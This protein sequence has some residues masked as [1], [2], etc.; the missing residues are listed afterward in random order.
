M[1][2]QKKK[3]RRLQNC[4]KCLQIKT[5][6]Y[7]SSGII[8]MIIILNN[9]KIQ[10]KEQHTTINLKNI[11]KKLYK[12]KR[13]GKW[14]CEALVSSR[15]VSSNSTQINSTRYFKY[16]G[17]LMYILLPASTRQRQHGQLKSLFVFKWVL[18]LFE[19][20]FD[21]QIQTK[22]VKKKYESIHC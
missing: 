3:L 19:S 18:N 22:K 7:S 5:G 20:Y 16:R 1:W 6:N 9:N 12:R 10:K 17:H 8:I 15:L 2:R 21:Q 14:S 13:F 11:K 4:W